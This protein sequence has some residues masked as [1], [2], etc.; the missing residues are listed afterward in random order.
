VS[1]AKSFDISKR[2][3][4]EAY[5]RVRANK[6]AAGVD[7]QTL[8]E[9]ELNLAD[10]LYK[11]WNRL[12]SGSYFPPPVRLVEIPKNDGGVRPLG[13]PTVTD[14]IAQAVIKARLEP[15]AEPHFHPDS[16]GYRP[17]K[18]ALD[19]V[20]KARERC[21]RRNWVVD[22]DITG[23][24]DNLDHDLVMRA[25]RKLTSCRVTC[26]YVERWLKAPLKTTDGT[27]VERVK[28]SPQGAVI[29][30]LLA[31]IFMHFAFDEWMRVEYPNITFE[32]YADDVVVHCASEQQAQNVRRAI[33]RRLA[34]CK[35]EAHPQKTKIVYC[36]DS[37]RQGSYENESFVFLGYEFR[38]RSATSR[39]GAT[40]I[41]FLPA[42]SK[43]ARKAMYQKLRKLRLHRRSDLSL[44][45]IVD[46]VDRILRGWIN[47]YGAFYSSALRPIFHHFHRILAKWVQRK[48]KKLRTAPRRARQW[49]ADVYQRQ[50]ELFTHWARGYQPTTG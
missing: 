39:K 20:G 6:G 10:N 41:S 45:E 30:P 28:G 38:P 36:K 23:F 9:F 37:N 35:L 33:D 31:N 11:L 27:L 49:L 46:R 29:S 22:L 7:R 5:K 43:Q 2:E 4:W 1:A 42:V 15:L 50:P 13:I 12:S 14:R 17:R 21:W 40:F 34:R 25:V 19:A 48:Y 44:D 26:L 47:Y 32:R 18:S 8:Q 3:L 24:F 16:Y